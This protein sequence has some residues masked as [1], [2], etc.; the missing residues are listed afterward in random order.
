[1]ATPKILAFPCSSFHLELLRQNADI[2]CLTLA[3]TEVLTPTTTAALIPSA[4]TICVGTESS[5]F[6]MRRFY[7]GL[8][9]LLSALSPDRVVIFNN[10]KPFQH[11]LIDTCFAQ[12][13]PVEMWEDGLGYYVSF[14]GGGSQLLWRGKLLGKL[15]LGYY[16]RGLFSPHYRS[17]ELILRDRFVTGNLQFSIPGIADAEPVS[18]SLFIGQPLVEQGFV[19]R[20]RFF[21][22]LAE[23]HRREQ[24]AI[25]YL[26]HPR[27]VFARRQKDKLA[28]IGFS[29]LPDAQVSAEQLCS[30]FRYV[31]VL[32]AFSTALLNVSPY[33]EAEFVPTP[34]R[35][36]AVRESL[37]ALLDLNVQVKVF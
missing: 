15:L 1:M 3:L 35:L 25:D 14:E 27:E 33:V 11:F 16:S 22:G 32:S 8:R 29:V 34:F 17:K 18:R 24:R 9:H 37:L 12:S 26:L 10:N 4:P 30:R 23:L 5:P 36:D 20:S 31:R 19:S 21:N 7:Q 13:I 6:G 28:A 2:S